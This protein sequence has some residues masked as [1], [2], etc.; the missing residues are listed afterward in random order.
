MNGARPLTEV[1]YELAKSKLTDLRDKCLLI[2]GRRTGFR[3]SEILSVNLID[4]FD[5]TKVRNYV[6]V[7]RG[8]MKGKRESRIVVL[9]PELKE[10][11]YLYIKTLNTVTL[12]M[13]LFLS[14][15]RNDRITRQAAHLILKK[16]FE[17]LE[18]NLS[19]HT[20]RKTLAQHMYHKTNNDLIK[21]QAILGHK[22]ITDT[23]KYLRPDQAEI[24]KLM[25]E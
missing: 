23:I 5:G 10:V 21:V 6:K 17:G 15:R 22:S 25:L 4:V 24:E 11:L 14:K 12:D 7:Q 3:I 1:E 20:M 19:T 18:G 9:H 2:F 13:P 16:A 8:Y